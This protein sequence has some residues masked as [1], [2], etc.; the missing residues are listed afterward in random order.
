VILVRL[1]RFWDYQNTDRGYTVYFDSRTAKCLY[2][3]KAV[4]ILV[5]YL[6]DVSVCL[7]MQVDYSGSTYIFSCIYSCFYSVLHS[8][9]QLSNV[10]V[11]L[12]AYY[13]IFLRK[14]LFGRTSSSIEFT[15]SFDVLIHEIQTCIYL[16]WTAFQRKKCSLVM[17]FYRPISICVMHLPVYVQLMS[18]ILQVC[19]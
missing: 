10:S 1:L 7:I 2:C 4:F 3:L 17:W 15:T 16:F 8:S 13:P 9:L 12:I 5:Y 19:I 11:C 6:L 14:N 18:I